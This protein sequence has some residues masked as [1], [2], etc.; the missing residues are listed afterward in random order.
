M[1]MIIDSG[2]K[3]RCLYHEVI[4]LAELGS[5]TITRASHVEPDEQGKWW[6]DMSPVN[7]PK[8]GPFEKRSEALEAEADW[9]SV[10]RLN[11]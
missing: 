4:A 10:H 1:E 5:L 11:S 6:A 2:G 7:G 9:I 3:V 8:L